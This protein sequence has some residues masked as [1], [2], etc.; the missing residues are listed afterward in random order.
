MKSCYTNGSIK[1]REVVMCLAVPMKLVEKNGM[2]GVVERGGVR[3]GV[4]LMLAPEAEPGDYLLIHAG[5]A[6]GVMDEGEAEKTLAL[7][8]ELLDAEAET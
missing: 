8:A 2:E 7:Y 5:Y 6:I 1:N 3:S 4:S